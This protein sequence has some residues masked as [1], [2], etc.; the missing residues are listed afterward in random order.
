MK[1]SV[2]CFLLGALTVNAFG[3]D[4]EAVF[5][6]KVGKF[7]VYML[8]ENRGSG[9]SGIL[10]GADE[11]LL[12]RYVPGG[13][14]QSE[15]NTFHIRGQ[16]KTV[17]VDTGFGGAIFE[18]MK[19]LGVDPSGVDAVL[20]THMHGDHIGGLQKDGKALFPNAKV[21][22]AAQE[23]EFWTKTR[24]N[25]GA[26]AALAPYGSRVETFLP[27]EIGLELAEL[28]PGIYP[29]AAFGHTPGHTV[30]LLDSKGSG[31]SEGEKLLIWGDVMHAQGIQF[32]VPGISVTYDTDPEAAAL[33]R[34]R[35]LDYAAK[36]RI[37]VAGMHLVYPAVGMV[38]AE[39]SGYRFAPL[40]RSET[41]K[42]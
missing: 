38:E 12:N 29:A 28:L 20:L 5:A 27:E 10:I 15:T 23:K 34:K 2:F 19:K 18:S 11:T 26:V 3:A 24:I 37:P 4:D 8:V 13:T 9:R 31:G 32:P 42:K 17:V 14:Y 40:K 6:C 30:F 7:D 16:G 25:Q 41:S 33:V 36:N 22:L 1:N 35:I 39:G 21:Y